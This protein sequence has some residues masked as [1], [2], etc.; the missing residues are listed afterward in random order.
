MNGQWALIQHGDVAWC[1]RCHRMIA[2]GRG[3]RYVV[4]DRLLPWAALC[5]LH[6]HPAWRRQVEFAVAV[7]TRRVDSDL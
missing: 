6:D 7:H 1:Y 2:P 4:K 3:A 5:G